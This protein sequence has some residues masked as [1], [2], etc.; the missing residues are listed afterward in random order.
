MLT[1]KSA[2]GCAPARTKFCAHAWLRV[3][4]KKLPTK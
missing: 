3:A 1:L 4:S 2:V